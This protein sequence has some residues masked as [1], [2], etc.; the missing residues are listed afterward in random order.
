MPTFEL[1]YPTRN[2]Q[3]RLR[4]L[5]FS[6]C[7]YTDLTAAFSEI[8]VILYTNKAKFTTGIKKY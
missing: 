7:T 5:Q 4:S 3:N 6:H 8:Y 2:L 1:C